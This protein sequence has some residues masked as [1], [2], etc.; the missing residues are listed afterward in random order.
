VRAA[1]RKSR[2]LGGEIPGTRVVRE[3]IAAGVPAAFSAA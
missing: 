1:E 2:A 3:P